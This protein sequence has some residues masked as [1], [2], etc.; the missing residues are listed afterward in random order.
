MKDGFYT[1]GGN[2]WVEY[3]QV[4]NGKVVC[5][6]ANSDDQMTFIENRNGITEPK[7]SNDYYLSKAVRISEPEFISAKIEFINL[8]NTGVV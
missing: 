1:Y 6:F 8:M 4:K 2:H 3:W 5:N 7:I